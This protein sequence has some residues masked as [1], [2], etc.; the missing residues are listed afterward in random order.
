MPDRRNGEQHPERAI[1]HIHIGAGHNA[2]NHTPFRIE[3]KTTKCA[4]SLSNTLPTSTSPF[5]V[6]PTMK[7]TGGWETNAN[8]SERSYT[9]GPI[10]CGN[11]RQSYGMWTIVARP[12]IVSNARIACLKLI[13]NNSYDPFR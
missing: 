3:G 13:S 8:G 7:I 10:E 11:K 2:A 4:T 9:N 12:T 6:Q 1:D 5:A